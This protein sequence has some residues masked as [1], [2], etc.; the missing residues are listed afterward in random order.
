MNQ[1]L[2]ASVRNDANPEEGERAFHLEQNWS[3]ESVG[4]ACSHRLFAFTQANG[5][6]PSSADVHGPVTSAL[7]LKCRLLKMQVQQHR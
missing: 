7:P 3:K 2:S 4:P 5:L 1:Y 6:Q